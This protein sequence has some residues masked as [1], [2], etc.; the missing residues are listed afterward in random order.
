MTSKAIDKENS[1]LFGNLS[2]ST[3]K[4]LGFQ[5]ANHQNLKEKHSTPVISLEKK[6]LIN[7]AKELANTV[8]K[9]RRALG[10][11]LNTAPN[12]QKTLGLGITP[13]IN[14]K[15]NI[16]NTPS[17]Q[18]KFAN[19]NLNDFQNLQNVQCVK[20]ES[21]QDE[22]LPPVEN[23]IGSKYDNFDDIFSD[24]RLSEI[25]LAQDNVTFGANLNHRS[26]YFYEQEEKI[27]ID[28]DDNDFIEMEL[29]KVKKSLKKMH[30][31]T[32][33]KTMEIESLD[34]LMPKIWEDSYEEDY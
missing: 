29:K 31:N 2:K 7:N 21:Q 23:F 8:G 24:G 27:Q 28:E 26:G 16:E 9:Q 18:K 1:S 13:K 12:R 20:K 19:L 22:E 34:D 15:I 4:S 14:R 25:L 32:E 17:D 6:T 5:N 11:V 3:A 33:L 10:D 30:K